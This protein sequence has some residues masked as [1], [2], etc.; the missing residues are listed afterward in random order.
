MSNRVPLSKKARFEVFKRDGFTCVYC[1]EQPPKVVL[2]CDHVHPVA[3]GGTND[4]DNLVTACDVCN[5]GKGPRTLS[6]VPLTVEQKAAL[7]EEREAQINAFNELVAAKRQRI[8]DTAW[9]VADVFLNRW[10]D[11]GIRKDWFASIERFVE[12]LS[13]DELLEAADIA[14]AKF[15][16]RKRPGFSYFCGICWRKIKGPQ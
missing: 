2:H 8:E 3:E 4:I 13:L 10:G 9:I 11:D 15:G 1:G 5:L 6:S 7:L 12:L 14:L 16:H